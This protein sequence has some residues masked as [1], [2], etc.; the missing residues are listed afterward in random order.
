MKDFLFINSINREN[1]NSSPDDF[2][3][4]LIKPFKTKK[5]ELT[6]IT[7]PVAHYTIM[8][9]IND[10]VTLTVSA[11]D[12]TMTLTQGIYTNFTD[13]TTELQTQLNAA[14]TVDNLFTVTYT[15][16]TQSFTIAHPTASSIF[17]FSTGGLGKMLGFYRQNT[18]SAVSHTSDQMATLVYDSN[19][20][21]HCHELVNGN[22]YVN[23]NYKSVVYPIP[24]GG[25][26]TDILTIDL[27]RDEKVFCFDTIRNFNSLNF[28]LTFSDGVTKVPLKQDWCMIFK[29]EVPY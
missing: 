5:L 29:Y 6:H 3:L 19:F 28:F 24:I 21:I 13:L 25:N 22:S 11:V 18:S 2:V 16:L 9:G 8:T 27:E 12:Y 4:K 10:S 20:L 7:L 17:K 23:N 14:Y 15:A 26:I 1:K